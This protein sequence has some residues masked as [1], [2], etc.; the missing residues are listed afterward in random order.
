MKPNFTTSF[1]IVYFLQMYNSSAD[2]RTYNIKCTSSNKHAT[3]IECKSSKTLNSSYTDGAGDVIPC[4]CPSDSARVIYYL[5]G[6]DGNESAQW[7]PIT[8]KD[9]IKAKLGTDII[10]AD[11]DGNNCYACGT[12]N[13]L[14]GTECHSCEDETGVEGATT[15]EKAVVG[16]YSCVIPKDTEE[17]TDE[18]GSFK[19]LADCFFTCTNDNDPLCK[20]NA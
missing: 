15:N 11:V 10:I 2:V 6:N 1:L 17:L 12:G 16:I 20:S 9:K 8:D 7:N 13:F 18:K 14:V 19:Y 5:C 3:T 4:V